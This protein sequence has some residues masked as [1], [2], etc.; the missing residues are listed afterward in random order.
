[1]GLLFQGGYYLLSLTFNYPKILALKLIHRFR[2]IQ[3]EKSPTKQNNKTKTTK[4]NK[5]YP[6]KNVANEERESLLGVG[7]SEL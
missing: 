1:M 3:Q 4:E 2:H 6:T 5:A 7:K